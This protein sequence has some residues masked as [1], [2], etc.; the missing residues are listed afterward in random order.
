ML[1]G[2]FTCYWVSKTF[3]CWKKGPRKQKNLQLI[4][5]KLAEDA[6]P[7]MSKTADPCTLCHNVC[8][9]LHPNQS[10]F[11]SP[12]DDDYSDT[13][14]ATY[15]VINNGET[16]DLSFTHLS[17]PVRLVLLHY[18]SLWRL[19]CPI[20]NRWLWPIDQPH[21]GPPCAP[22]TYLQANPQKPLRQWQDSGA[23]TIPCTPTSS[24][25]AISP[26]AEGQRQWPRERLI[27]C[28]R[29]AILALNQ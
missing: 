21:H 10:L 9:C 11:L 6:I 2:F 15:A 22:D 1:P 7:P 3:F 4:L 25:H 19:L 29:V 18:F 14:N 24:A 17:S 5:F 13:Y 23:L 8:S 12:P 16:R 20:S 27:W 28:V 26:P